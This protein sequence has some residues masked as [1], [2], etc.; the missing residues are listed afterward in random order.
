MNKYKLKVGDRVDSTEGSIYTLAS[1]NNREIQLLRDGEVVSTIDQY[2]PNSRIYR[3][4]ITDTSNTPLLET[5]DID[6]VYYYDNESDEAFW[7]TTIPQFP[8]DHSKSYYV[9]QAIGWVQDGEVQNDWYVGLIATREAS[10]VKYAVMRDKGKWE[11]GRRYVNEFLKNEAGINNP[12]S[13][14][15]VDVVYIESGDG[16][17]YYQLIVPE[18][19]DRISPD[20]SSKKWIQATQ[21][22]FVYIKQLIADEIDSQLV[23]TNNLLIKG[24]DNKVVAGIAGNEIFT[25]NNDSGI[26]IWAGSNAQLDNELLGDI[27]NSPFRVYQSGKVVADQIEITMNRD[28]FKTDSD[29]MLPI[30]KVGKVGQLLITDNSSHTISCSSSSILFQNSAREYQLTNSLPLT[31]KGMYFITG[32]MY[33]N[34]PVWVI[35]EN[36]TSQ[37]T[38]VTVNTVQQIVEENIGSDIQSSCSFRRDS[39]TNFIYFDIPSMLISKDSDAFREIMGSSIS[40]S[41]T[42]KITF[43]C[44]NNIKN[45][46]DDEVMFEGTCEI[47]L[48]GHTNDSV[49][50]EPA[51]NVINFEIQK[52]NGQLK[53]VSGSI[54][55]GRSDS[56]PSI[57]KV[58]AKIQIIKNISNQVTTETPVTQ[59][60][61]AL[62]AIDYGTIVGK[63]NQTAETITNFTDKTLIWNNAGTEVVIGP[64]V[65][66]VPI[67]NNSE[68][69]APYNP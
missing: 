49:S 20:N 58:E 31:N 55:I 35:T 7:K 54:L 65:E 28:L 39:E 51:S 63:I 11:S 4:G 48:D 19:Q 9:W 52:N 12:T 5:D 15:Y 27:Q 23:Q 62:V 8:I 47:Y 64:R 26:R 41:V 32:M 36:S 30:A 61:D 25:D 69:V 60:G 50:F 29:L 18:T 68:P 21:F 56:V 46:K 42:G 44:T 38:V 57:S 2:Q 3:Y 33:S 43:D 24:Q 37:P 13:V 6:S 16:R 10:I 66:D 67:D 14:Y 40:P 53:I 17:E 45:H 59:V 1:G 34:Q 22:D